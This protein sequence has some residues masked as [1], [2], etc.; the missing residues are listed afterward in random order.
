[1]SAVWPVRG[2][3]TLAELVQRNIEL[4][5]S[6]EWSQEEQDLARALQAKAK[7]KVEGL[8][9]ATPPVTSG[10]QKPSA[11]DSGDVSWKV[12]MVKFYYPANIPNIKDRKSTRLNSR[13]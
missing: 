12:P 11:N 6:P 13:H 4:V 5:G 7:V 8:R 9:S 3:R 1:M 2:N 10:A